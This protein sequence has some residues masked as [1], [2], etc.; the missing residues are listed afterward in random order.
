MEDILNS[1][2][3]WAWILGAYVA[4]LL[5]VLRAITEVALALRHA[6]IGVASAFESIETRFETLESQGEACKELLTNLKGELQELNQAVD[7][8]EISVCAIEAAN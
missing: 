3:R 5:L 2:P 4:G 6:A 8:I 7:R 1:I